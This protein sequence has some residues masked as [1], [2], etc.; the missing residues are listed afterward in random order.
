M[1]GLLQEA[2]YSSL[3]ELAQATDEELL[4]VPGIGQGRLA[5]IRAATEGRPYR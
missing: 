1:A 2:G 3:E 5:V 4:A